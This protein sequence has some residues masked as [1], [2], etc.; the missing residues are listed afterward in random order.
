MTDINKA[1]LAALARKDEYPTMVGYYE[2]QARC[3]GFLREAWPNS[4]I[5]A[6]VRAFRALEEVIEINQVLGITRQKAHELVDQVFD[7]PVGELE[8]EAGGVAFTIVSL[9]SALGINMIH[10]GLGSVNEAYGRIDKIR[11]KNKLK[12]KV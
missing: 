2:L 7:K 1:Q 3:D 9:F 5:Q 8:Q 10:S 12:V 6:H 11:E 4:P